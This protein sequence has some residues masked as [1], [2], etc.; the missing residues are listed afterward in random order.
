[1]EWLTSRLL[2]SALLMFSYDLDCLTGKLLNEPVQ[3]LDLIGRRCPADLSQ[4]FIR[5]GTFQ[6]EVGGTFIADGTDS[7]KITW[8]ISASHR[9]ID[10]M[11]NVKA[12]LATEVIWVSLTRHRAAHLASETI[13]IK[14]VG[15]SFFGNSSLKKRPPCK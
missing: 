2:N 10:N 3:H 1:M 8:I 15:T 5:K 12:S 14:D 11:A 13:S 4:Y 6:S 9:F 7:T